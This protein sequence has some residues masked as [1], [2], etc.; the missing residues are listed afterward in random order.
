MANSKFSLRAC[1]RRIQQKVIDQVIKIPDIV[2]WATHM[3]AN[4]TQR[5]GVERKERENTHAHTFFFKVR[6]T[7]TI[8]R[9]AMTHF[10]S[11]DSSG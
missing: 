4:H 9:K 1:L 11:F 5:E 10:S 2:L 8:K 6:G 7:I 3:C